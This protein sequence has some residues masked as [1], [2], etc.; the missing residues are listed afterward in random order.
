MIRLHSG[1][2]AAVQ[3]LKGTIMLFNNCIVIKINNKNEHEDT[4]HSKIYHRVCIDLSSTIAVHQ[5]LNYYICTGTDPSEDFKLPV[6][7]VYGV[8]EIATVTFNLLV[9]V[10]I[11]IFKYFG[12]NKISGDHQGQRIKNAFL[13][14]VK[15]QSL[16]SF[17]INLCNL[18][19]IASTKIGLSLLSQIEPSRLPEKGFL[20]HAHYALVPGL[21]AVFY[22]VSFY[23][24]HP[25]MRK[26][27]F[28]KVRDLLFICPGALKS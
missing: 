28:K 3:L 22:L 27:I 18:I 8:V 25:P 12:K 10:K 17:S 16:A 21:I 26:A 14:E 4:T 23:A 6:Q 24:K 11:R 19:N 20:I 9:F 15:Q 2:Y 7:K 5:P 13:A 1:N